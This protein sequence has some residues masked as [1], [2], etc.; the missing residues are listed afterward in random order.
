MA[1][2]HLDA[3]QVPAQLRGAYN[4]KRFTAEVSETVFIPR[5]ADLWQDGQRDRY[6]AIELAT[7]KT[8]APA[9]FKLAPWDNGR[10]DTTVTLR[11]GFAVVRHTQGFMPSMHFYVHASDAIALLPAP[12]AELT[13]VEKIVLN[14]T[15]SY[16][17][18]YGGRDR[19]QMA[20]DDQRWSKDPVAFNRAAWD[21][22]KESLIAK[23]LLNKAGAITVA[24]RNA[25]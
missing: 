15:A 2:I 4:G 14:A 24:G 6:Y 22:A 16:K 3:K 7:G 9:G 19:Y 21:A 20:Q 13:A 1:I 5:D 12:R 23:G 8:S 10:G 17:S 18:S 25:R 11:A